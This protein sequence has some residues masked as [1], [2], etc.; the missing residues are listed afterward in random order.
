MKEILKEM[1]YRVD[2]KGRRI[3][4]GEKVKG[5]PGPQ[6]IG[7]YYNSPKY[8]GEEDNRRRVWVK[9]FDDYNNRETFEKA[10]QAKGGAA[11]LA[12]K[13]NIMPNYEKKEDRVINWLASDSFY[14]EDSFFYV[15]NLPGYEN[16]TVA[17]QLRLSNHF[18]SP[19]QWFNSHIRRIYTPRGEISRKSQMSQFGLCLL[20]DRFSNARDIN[21][22]D[23]KKEDIEMYNTYGQTFYE[24]DLNL[25]EKTEVQKKKIE[26]FLTNIGLGKNVK[27]TFQELEYM[28]G[29]FPSPIKFCGDKY[30]D[31]NFTERE[32]IKGRKGKLYP[33]K[34]EN[35]KEK[36]KI[37]YDVI[38]KVIYDKNTEKVNIGG[39]NYYMFKY[40][41]IDLA[42]D[43]NMNVYRR[44]IKSGKL[45]NRVVP[46]DTYSIEENKI[47]RLT[48][49]ESEIKKMIIE[50][51][52]QIRKRRLV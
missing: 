20:I 15:K 17:F 24:I 42:L 8:Y 41:G 18:V 27:V 45:Q 28:F 43:D 16:K 38:E 47:R 1:F 32:N 44:G 50:C 5:W 40:D 34:D 36:I 6:Y 30:D 48:I 23:I 4:T 25:N 21:I 7:Y 9:N 37:P 2:D 46:D 12:Y 3:D 52:K 14:N 19:T 31:V 39:K 22:R 10:V 29:K 49:T 33:F 11:P 26:E 51:V 35:I 13:Y